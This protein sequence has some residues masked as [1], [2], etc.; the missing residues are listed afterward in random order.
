MFSFFIMLTFYQ[1]FVFQGDKV[2]WSV[3]QLI[4]DCQQP[5]SVS[6]DLNVLIS[7]IVEHAQAGDTI[8]VMSNGG[9]GGIHQKLLDQLSK[10]FGEQ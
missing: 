2:E 3:A 8:V 4:D 5:C 9:F 7:S 6:D 10:K 1:V